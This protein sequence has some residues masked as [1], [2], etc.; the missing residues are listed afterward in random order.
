MYLQSIDLVI[1]VVT[2][3]FTLIY[4]YCINLLLLLLLPR[5]LSLVD[6]FITG[7]LIHNDNKSVS[8]KNISE[9]RFVYTFILLTLVNILNKT[10][11]KIFLYHTYCMY[12][13]ARVYDYVYMYARARFRII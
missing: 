12:M 5:T 8:R 11:N 7:Y 10:L 3:V 13:R 2:Y 6:I 4:Y 1:K 9:N